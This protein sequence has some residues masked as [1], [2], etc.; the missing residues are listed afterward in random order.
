MVPRPRLMRATY[1]RVPTASAAVLSLMLLADAACR[2]DMLTLNFDVPGA[3]PGKQGAGGWGALVLSFDRAITASSFIFNP[4]C[5]TATNGIDEVGD[6]TTLLRPASGTY[7]LFATGSTVNGGPNDGQIR[8]QFQVTI[9]FPDGSPPPK[10]TD[11]FW[12]S[13]PGSRSDPDFTFDSTADLRFTPEP[14]TMVLLLTLV[15]GYGLFV[16]QRKWRLQHCQPSISQ[17]ASA[18]MS[19]ESNWSVA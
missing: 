4:D 13:K 19:H 14:S 7:N 18:R 9:T 11:G 10:V 2:A 5:P 17:T 12:K 8:G 15:L 16:L 1:W 3:L 6:M